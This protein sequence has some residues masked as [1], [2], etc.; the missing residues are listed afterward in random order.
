[1]GGGALVAIWQTYLVLLDRRICDFRG[2]RCKGSEKMADGPR[3][4][5]HAGR[6]LFIG[7]GWPLVESAIT[8]D[9]N[10]DSHS[11]P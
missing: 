6:K 3:Q 9:R 11:L 8:L 4:T 10:S 7:S 5:Q 2:E 1:M